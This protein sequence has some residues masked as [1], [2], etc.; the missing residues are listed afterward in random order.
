V[1]GNVNQV[2]GQIFIDFPV[3]KT[4]LYGDAS[5]FFRR[6]AVSVNPCQFFGQ[7]SFAVV[8]MTCCADDYSFQSSSLLS[9]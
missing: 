6:Q 8:D 5:A 9:Y 7:Q 1:S 4:Q 2:G 3:S